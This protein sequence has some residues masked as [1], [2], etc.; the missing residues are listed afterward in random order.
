MGPDATGG[1]PVLVAKVNHQE[2][3]TAYLVPRRHLLLEVAQT[4]DPDIAFVLILEVGSLI[5]D[6]SSLP[7][8]SGTIHHEVVADIA[9]AVASVSIEVGS[10]NDLDPSGHL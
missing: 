2:L 1:N 3:Q 4:E 8:P 7:D 9:P 10:S 5:L 6:R